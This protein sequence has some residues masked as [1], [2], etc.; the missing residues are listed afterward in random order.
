MR[1]SINSLNTLPKKIS[2]KFQHKIASK[3]FSILNTISNYFSNPNTKYQFIKPHH[4]IKDLNY[5]EEIFEYFSYNYQNMHEEDF[6]QI[7]DKLLSTYVLEKEVKYFKF[8]MRD[9]LEIANSSIDKEGNIN[10]R[11]FD[12]NLITSWVKF[13]NKKFGEIKPLLENIMNIENTE[14]DRDFTNILNGQFK[15]LTAH[16]KLITSNENLFEFFKFIQENPTNE[17]SFS[18]DL[19]CSLIEN[20]KNNQ[21]FSFGRPDKIISFEK[22][23]EINLY[24]LIAIH[25]NSITDKNKVKFF[26]NN[27][28][29]NLK[30]DKRDLNF[31]E[32]EI[33]IL[34]QIY[35]ISGD[36]INKPKETLEIDLK[37]FSILNDEIKLILESK[38]VDFEKLYRS[39]KIIK[40]EVE[41]HKILSEEFEEKLKVLDGLKSKYM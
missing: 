33:K 14:I 41:E 35:L 32:K 11:F 40:Q 10:P 3:N 8:I 15:F 29:I 26:L 25:E 34:E 37:E 21:N 31:S 38:N 5:K 7:F 39:Y 19:W 1:K 17:K 30:F 13:F 2:N 6:I 27:F 16:A 12:E 20:F 18:N 4:T 22:L 28:L 24:H 9:F 36:I 23:A